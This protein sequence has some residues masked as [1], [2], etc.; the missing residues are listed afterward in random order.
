MTNNNTFNF[1]KAISHITSNEKLNS[2]TASR[3]G[4]KKTVKIKEPL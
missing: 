2:V 1:T 3:F 4:D